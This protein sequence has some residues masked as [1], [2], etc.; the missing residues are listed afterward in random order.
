MYDTRKQQYIEPDVDN[1][2]AILITVHVCHHLNRGNC[3]LF[4]LFHVSV[5]ISARYFA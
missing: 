2:S 5:K 4:Q 1:M 3:V